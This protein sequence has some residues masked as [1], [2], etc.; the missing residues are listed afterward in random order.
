MNGQETELNAA[1]QH[2][3][4][5]PPRTV[6]YYASGER[7]ISAYESNMDA[8]MFPRFLRFEQHVD[9]MYGGTYQ[10]SVPRTT[11]F[12][13]NLVNIPAN[14]YGAVSNL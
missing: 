1:K 4:R 2:G 5:L 11:H 7:A 13:R 12:C 8:L 6:Q 3:H 14:L 10:K 9:A